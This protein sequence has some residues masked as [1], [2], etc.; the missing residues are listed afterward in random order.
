MRR[1][2]LEMHVEVL[3]ALAFYGPMRLTHIT[4]KANLSYNL[5][6]QVLKEL[7]RNELVEERIVGK[8]VVVYA[9]TNSARTTLS[10]FKEL[11]QILPIT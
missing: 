1:S 2:K 8:N 6:K 9:A 4:Y 11:T 5:L 10:K 3:D 7:I